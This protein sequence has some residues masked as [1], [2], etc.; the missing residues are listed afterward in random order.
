[1]KQK[2]IMYEA[3]GGQLHK[4]LFLGLDNKRQAQWLMVDQGKEVMTL[5]EFQESASSGNDV[6]L[7]CLKGE[8][9][10]SSTMALLLGAVLQSYGPDVYGMM[11]NTLDT[12]KKWNVTWQRKPLQMGGRL[13]EYV[14]SIKERKCFRFYID[15]KEAGFVAEADAFDTIDEM[16]EFLYHFYAALE[17]E[18]GIKVTWKIFNTPDDLLA[19]ISKVDKEIFGIE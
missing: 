4:C 16:M 3:I 8:K 10:E 13:Q 17:C 5:R 18:A 15:C 12:L 1:M 2:A 11:L 6:L 19:R 14:D 7:L 9:V